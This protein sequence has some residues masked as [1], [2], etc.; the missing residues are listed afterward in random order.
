MV[1]DV[2]VPVDA[3]L[4]KTPILKKLQVDDDDRTTASITSISSDKKSNIF[5]ADDEQ[6]N[7]KKIIEHSENG[8]VKRFIKDLQK[9]GKNISCKNS[10]TAAEECKTIFIC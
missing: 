7:D 2:I 5:D 8:R 6:T 3:R 9:K 1:E 4:R 10:D